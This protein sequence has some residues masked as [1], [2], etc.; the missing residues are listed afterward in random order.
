MNES[1]AGASIMSGHIT[2]DGQGAVRL[3]EWQA[4]SPLGT[5]KAGTD[6]PARQVEAVSADLSGPAKQLE[7]ELA[8][9]CDRN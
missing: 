4:G 5:R 1:P 2:D 6:H 8:A 7:A 3:I 9:V